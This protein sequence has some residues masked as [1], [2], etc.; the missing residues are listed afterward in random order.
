MTPTRYGLIRRGTL[1]GAALWLC[2]CGETTASSSNSDGS[3]GN[4]NP[5]SSM[6]GSG[7]AGGNTATSGGASGSVTSGGRG[8]SGGAG[9]ATV[10][11]GAAGEGGA[12]VIPTEKFLATSVAAGFDAACAVTPSAEVACWGQVVPSTSDQQVFFP[13]LVPGLTDIAAVR[14]AWDTVCALSEAGTLQCWGDGSQG[15]LGNDRS[16]DGYS[17]ESPVSVVGLDDVVDFSHSGAAC[18]VRSDGSV[19]CWGAND[20]GQLGFTSETCGLYAVQLD[21][22]VYVE[23]DCQARPRRVPGIESAVQVSVGTAHECAVLAD[24]SVVCWGASDVWGE[25]GRGQE[26]SANPEVPAPVIGLSGVRKVAVGHYFTCALTNAGEVFCWGDN[27]QGGLGRGISSLDLYSDPSPGPVIGLGKV[28]DLAVHYATACAVT[29]GGE[30]YCWAQMADLLDYADKPDQ[31]SS[32]ETAPVLIPY[33]SDAV[34]VSTQGFVACAVQ[35]SSELVC[36]GRN[37]SGATGNGQIEGYGDF[38]GLPVVWD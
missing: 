21:S 23:H 10:T 9:G 28:T 2:A 11:T 36:W 18:A 26:D 24:E 6:T 1:L 12:F 17:E 4:G 13:V 19:W 25:L 14:S 15:Q 7:G 22:I 27:G 8:G 34:Q 29:E 32:V 33:V 31:T 5:S 35:I 30:V 3:G 38:S 16:G 20:T 37:G